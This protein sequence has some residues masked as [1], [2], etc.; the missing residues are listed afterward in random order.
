MTE[1]TLAVNYRCLLSLMQTIASIPCLPLKLMKSWLS[2]AYVWKALGLVLGM[3]CTNASHR[4][5]TEHADIL[6]FRFMKNDQSLFIKDREAGEVQ[7]GTV[8]WPET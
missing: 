1:H 5:L 3:R 4:N 2:P 7:G 6:F 8:L